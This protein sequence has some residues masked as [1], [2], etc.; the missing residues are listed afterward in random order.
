M[1]KA[2]KMKGE[3]NNMAATY[4]K[5]NNQQRISASSAAASA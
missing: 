2:A 4:V 1:K 5:I 3:S